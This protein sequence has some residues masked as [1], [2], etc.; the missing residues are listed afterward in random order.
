MNHL[1]VYSPEV[2]G[3]RRLTKRLTEE[4]EPAGGGLGS[5][6]NQVRVGFCV[7]TSDQLVSLLL[8]RT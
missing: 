4:A 8:R 2:L 3:W 7:L 1:V 6:R 5:E